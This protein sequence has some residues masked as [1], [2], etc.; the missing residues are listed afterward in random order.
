MVLPR[1]QRRGGGLVESRSDLETGRGPGGPE[2]DAG[3]GADD[4]RGGD[5]RLRRRACRL[6][7]DGGALRR[8][9]PSNLGYRGADDRPRVLRRFEN[10]RRTRAARR[11]ALR[12]SRRPLGRGSDG[13]HP[14]FVRGRC[15]RRHLRGDP[16]PPDRSGLQATRRSGSGRHRARHRA[17]PR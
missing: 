2:R 11:P 17:A 1:A 6:E 10:D 13:N 15:A 16:A 14:G 5:H 8:G 4:D 9:L 7:N 12:S 3:G